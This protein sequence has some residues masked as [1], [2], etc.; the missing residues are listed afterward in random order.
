[1]DSETLVIEGRTLKPWTKKLN[2]IWWFGNDDEQ[3]VD[4]ADWYQP[5]W[6]Y[7]RRWLYWNVFRNPLQNFRCYVV[8][9]A[10]RNYTVVGKPP[11]TCVQRNDLEPPEFGWQWCIIKLGI[12]RFP[13]V[14]YSGVYIVWYAGWQP[15]G[16]FGIKFN[17]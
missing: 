17:L 9:V 16:F 2:P 7:W 3:T 8:G 12:F 1:M 6:P 15:S 10:D 4:E 14:S 13:F 5:E 11:V